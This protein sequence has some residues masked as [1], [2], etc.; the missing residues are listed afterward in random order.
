MS[1]TLLARSSISCSALAFYYFS[2]EKFERS[3]EYINK[4]KLDYFI[5]KYDV[6]NL[7]L[8]LYFELGY[9]EEAISM[10]HSYR[11]LLRKDVFLTDSRKLRN[12]N[13][14]K[15]LRKLII[16]KIDN[17]IK[18]IENIKIDLQNINEIRYKRW[19]ISKVDEIVES[20]MVIV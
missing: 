17:N 3:L 5:Y 12:R 9:D 19:L 10:I 16:L 14:I 13:F 1:L 11:E 18:D 6:K 20:R 8:K 2:L 15:Y 4:I 7:M